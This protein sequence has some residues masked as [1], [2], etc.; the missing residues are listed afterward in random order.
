MSRWAR[1]RDDNHRAILKG[2]ADL[3]IWHK[4]T[5]DYPRFVDVL[6]WYDGRFH[7]L[8]IK[9]EKGPRG[10]GG[11][12]LTEAQK[13]LSEECPGPIPVVRTL[14]EALEAIGARRR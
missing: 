5:A 13:K 14:D 4:D 9:K 11:G 3:R 12:T 1:K 2:L 7:L 6:V 10:G 8:E